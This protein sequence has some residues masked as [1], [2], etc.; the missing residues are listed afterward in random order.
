MERKNSN[1]APTAVNMHNTAIK[2]NSFLE[3][4]MSLLLFVGKS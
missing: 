2:E 3:N 4:N 1:T